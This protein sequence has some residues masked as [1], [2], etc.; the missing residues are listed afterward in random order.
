VDVER[1]IL[2]S[3]NNPF[4]VRMHWSFESNSSAYFILEHAEGGDLLSVMDNFYRRGMPED[5]TRF[6]IA[7]I[8]LA[9]EYLHSMNVVVYDLKPSNCLTTMLGHIKLADFSHSKIVLGETLDDISCAG[10]PE[11]IAPETLQE[12]DSTKMVDYWSLGIMLYEMLFSLLPWGSGED[13]DFDELFFRVLTQPVSFPDDEDVGEGGEDTGIR[14]TGRGGSGS[15]GGGG[16]GE[17]GAEMVADG[18]EVHVP[19]SAAASGLITALL[20]KEPSS[21]LG[22]DPAGV[23]AH[24]FF[25]LPGE[26]LDWAKAR[27]GELVPPPR[28]IPRQ[29][30]TGAAANWLTRS[31]QR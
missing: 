25:N 3:S 17:E 4:V 31:N 15:G 16:G 5:H 21:R 10:T 28:E 1:E 24:M 19:V 30:C 13:S 18:S 8:L 26:E 27:R 2:A 22:T 12:Q 23:K 9:L 29:P 14:S 6:Y 7:E 11:Y 20:E